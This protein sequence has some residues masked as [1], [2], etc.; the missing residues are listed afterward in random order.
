MEFW[1]LGLAILYSFLRIFFLLSV[2]VMSLR[3]LW[4]AHYFEAAITTGL[5]MLVADVAD[6]KS[7]QGNVKV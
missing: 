4:Q 1:K 2:G 5:I 6:I 7:R 3:F